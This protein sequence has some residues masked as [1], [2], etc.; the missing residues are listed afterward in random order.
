[1]KTYT[2]MDEKLLNC[3]FC[4]GEAQAFK[5]EDEYEYKYIRC[6]EGCLTQYVDPPMVGIVERRIWQSRVPK[7]SQWVEEL[8]TESGMYW[9]ASGANMNA[10]MAEVTFLDDNTV[11]VTLPHSVREWD[12]KDFI[13]EYN[14]M[15]W[16][17]CEPPP[18]SDLSRG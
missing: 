10:L 7:Q 11:E 9:Y 8:P 6:R 15:A 14:V 1:M 13:K 2:I 5:H 16:C 12:I 18:G 4:G 17:L 3:P